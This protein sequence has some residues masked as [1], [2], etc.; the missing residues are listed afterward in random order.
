MPGKVLHVL[1]VDAL[2]EEVGEGSDAE[3]VGRVEQGQGEK[4]EDCAKDSVGERD[5]SKLARLER[6]VA[7][8]RLKFVQHVPEA[9]SAQVASL[10]CQTGSNTNGIRTGPASL[11]SD[12][13]RDH[14]GMPFGFPS[15]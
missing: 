6:K 8:M 3:G 2:L 1:A 11:C 13:V 4:V 12:G 5:R 10:C 14:P 9:M 7:S 15:D